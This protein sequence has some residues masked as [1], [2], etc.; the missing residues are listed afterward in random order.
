M[1]NS[2]TLTSKMLTRQE[3]LKVSGLGLAGATLLGT[4]GCGG[5]GGSGGEGGGS[6]SEELLFT[7]SGSSYQR[8]QTK[9]WL[10]PYFNETGTKIRQDS[11]TDYAKIQSMVENN[12]VV[13]DVVNVS[14]DFG[15][16]ST[17][18][19]LEPLDY[20]VI[21]RGPILEGYASEYRIACMLYANTLAYN[22]EQID[23]TPSAWADLFDTRKFTGQRGF[24]KSPWETLEVALL[25]DD[26]L[27]EDLYP[28]D[29]DRALAKLDTIKD[30]IV[31]WETGGQLQQQLA[32][33]EVA[34]ASAWNG[35]VQ[36]EIDAGTPVKIQWNQNLQTADYLVVPKGTANKEQAMELIA[37]CVSAENNHRLSEF[38][39]YAPINKK[40]IPKVDPQVT[41][42]LPTAYREVGVT[43][44]AEWWDN[45][46]EAVE[47]R[48]NQW[49]MN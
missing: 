28:L 42:Q 4:S 47:Q 19:L 35:R 8:A 46:R 29:V 6:A 17:A 38:I 48:F 10:N 15:L 45:N 20:S 21:D 39:P 30:E 18:D 13:W 32:D 26:V 40:S 9:A 33:G 41:S 37:Y 11:P 36:K 44:N 16:Q 2:K 3:F 43:F 1:K 23:G 5:G 27:P 12:N 49:L 24:R 31:W 25:G 7:S 34:L 22:T 14:N